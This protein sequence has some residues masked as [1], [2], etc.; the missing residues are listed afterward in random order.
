[1]VKKSVLFVCSGN[2]FRSMSAKFLFEKYL[3]DNNINDWIVDSA[4]T[5]AKK[6]T[7]RT[8]LIKQL[9]EYGV[10]P[11]KHKQKKLT[12]KHLE[13]YD[14]IIAMSKD[15]K[16]FIEKQFNFKDVFLYNEFAIKK[17][18]SVDDVNTIPHYEN[19]SDLVKKHIKKVVTHLHKTM[20]DFFNEIN[21]R[22]YLFSD[23]VTGKKVHRNGYP[24]I[25]LCENKNALAFM[26]I[27]IPDKEDSHIL[28]IPK[29]RYFHFYQI[30]K[31]TVSD[32]M[33][34]IQK[35]GNTI[36]DEHDGY[37]ILLNDGFSAGQ[38]QYHVHFHII[39]RNLGDKIRIEVWNHKT[40]TKEDFIKYNKQLK[41]KLNSK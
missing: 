19:N 3:K 23:L 41:N 39:P 6:Q 27:D 36:Y 38:W 14:I 15:H 37:N 32:I 18:T 7:M 24:F 16:E 35:I 2:I 25:V 30:P 21:T 28:V 40:P 31:T 29:K 22:F 5:T 9:N 11:T 13:K 1:M 12:K 4:G 8:T 26:S 17:S 34:L 10:D 33:Q 20:P